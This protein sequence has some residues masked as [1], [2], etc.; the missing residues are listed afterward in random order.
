M[1]D[2]ALTVPAILLLIAVPAAAAVVQVPY[3]GELIDGGTP[4]TGWHQIDVSLWAAP[5]GGTA[6]HSQS[7]TLLV[8]QGVFHVALLVDD[9]IFAANDS[10]W[11]GVAV[12]G[13]AELEPRVRIGVVPYAARA[14]S[15]P[16]TGTAPGLA[17]ATNFAPVDV[18]AT[19]TWV[20]VATVTLNA[21]ADGQVWLS[22][23]GWW[24]ENSNTLPNYVGVE[25][26]LGENVA[27]PTSQRQQ[28]YGFFQ[29]RSWPFSHTTALAAT[30]GAHTYSCWVRVTS[31]GQTLA[32]PPTV[33]AATMQALWVPGSYGN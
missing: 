33:H 20:E 11:A 26:I 28:Y 3:T 24:Q 21:P 13:A 29:F 31:P 25:F 22:A 18:P 30:A 8:E 4:L 15:A 5:A 17:F 12:D 6:V 19:I 2:T 27:P 7:A 10:L 9:A 14:L 32:S 16:P 23:T 1:R